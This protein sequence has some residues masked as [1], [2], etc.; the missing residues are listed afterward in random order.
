ML[1]WPD[2]GERILR[3]ILLY[4]PDLVCLEEVDHF[5][6]FFSSKLQERGYFSHFL[7][8]PNSPCLRV[9]GNS[10]P[11]GCAIFVKKDRLEVGK[12]LEIALHDGEESVTNQVAILAVVKDLRTERKFIVGVTHL[13]AKDGNECIRAAQGKNLLGKL[14]KMGSDCG[15]SPIV[16][17]GDFNAAP[18][19]LVYKEMRDNGLDS[20][21]SCAAKSEP[22]FTTWK[23]RPT[24]EVRRTIDYVW[25]SPKFV[26]HNY[27]ET[28]S[29]DVIGRTALPSFLFPSDHLSL[30]FDLELP[31]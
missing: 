1:S 19:E 17:C 2:R 20:S 16:L 4:Y 28:P 14:W 10:G 12:L 31:G 6:D 5:H 30:V 24:G 21:Y 13:K 11:D 23:Y 15:V 18:N 7:P 3:E 27:L 26:V 9:Q 29:Q 8:K 22:A 25:H